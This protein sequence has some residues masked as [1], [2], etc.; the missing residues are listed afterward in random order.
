MDL[1]KLQGAR[2]IA[3]DRFQEELSIDLNYGQEIVQ[4]VR[5]K[6]CRLVCVLQSAR[7]GGMIA[8]GRILLLTYGSPRFFQIQSPPLRPWLSLSLLS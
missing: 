7:P 2:G 8:R 6:A 1:V 3:V 4:L 5:D